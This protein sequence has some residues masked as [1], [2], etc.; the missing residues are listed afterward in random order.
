MATSSNSILKLEGGGGGNSSG[1]FSIGFYLKNAIRPLIRISFTNVSF[2]IY[3]FI[4][5]FFNDRMQIFQIH[6]I[7]TLFFRW[8]FVNGSSSFLVV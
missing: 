7:F 1:L 2:K 8:R 4:G 6:G 5:K 3:N